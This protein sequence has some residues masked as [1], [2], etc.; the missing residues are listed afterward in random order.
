MSELT[1]TGSGAA[2]GMDALVGRILIVGVLSSLGLLTA[3]LVW[4]WSS[5]GAA[6][7]TN[8]W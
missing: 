7:W 1:R 6:L 5:T 4:H 3:G 8:P 2:R